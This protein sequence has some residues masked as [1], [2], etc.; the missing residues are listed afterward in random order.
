MKKILFALGLLIVSILGYSQNTHV[1]PSLLPSHALIGGKNG[2]ATDTPFVSDMNTMQMVDRW[3]YGTGFAASDTINHYGYQNV[4]VMPNAINNGT[5]N[6]TGYGQQGWLSNSTTGGWIKVVSPHGV[7]IGNSIVAG[8]TNPPIRTSGLEQNNMN[9]QDS[10]SQIGYYITR[11]CMYPCENMGIGGQTTVQIKARFRRDVLG[12]SDVVGDGRTLP[13][14]LQKAAFCI[15]EGG[16]ND[17]FQ[18]IPIPLATVQANLLWM[19]EQCQEY[20]IPCIVLNSVG[21]GASAPSYS[22]A[23][24]D[25]INTWEASGDLQKY[26]AVVVDINSFWNS[27][28]DGGL[29]AYHNNNF[30]PSSFVNTGDF[31]HFTPVGYDSVAQIIIRHAKLPVL[32]KIAFQSVLD[33]TNP[34]ANY[35]RPTG[36]TI[37]GSAFFGTASQAFSTSYTLANSAYDT[38]LVTSAILTDTA[39]ITITSSS[40]SGSVSGWSNIL[41]HLTNNPTGQVWYTQRPPMSGANTGNVVGTTLNLTSQTTATVP[42]LTINQSAGAT[43]GYGVLVNMSAGSTQM[44]INGFANTTPINSSILNVF[45]G[46]GTSGQL[47]SQST[48]GSQFNNWVIGG[49]AAAAATGFGLGTYSGGVHLNPSSS[50]TLAGPIVTI[51]AASPTGYQYI[52]S[53]S[54]VNYPALLLNQYYSSLTG[55][56]DTVP[57]L[58]LYATYNDTITA[59]NGGMLGGVHLRYTLTNIGVMKLGGFWN[60]YG[61]NWLNGLGGAT[62]IGTT[63]VH[64]SAKLD[65][66]DSVRGLLPPRMTS[67]QISHIGYVK[68]ATVTNGGSGYTVVPK[69][70][71]SGGNGSGARGYITTSSSAVSAFTIV[72][73]GINY[74]GSSPVLTI[75][76]GPGVN[77]AVTLNVSGPDTGLIVYNATTNAI[78]YFN[79]TVWVPLA[80]L[81]HT[82]TTPAAGGTV[83]LVNNQYNIVNSS[84]SLLALT[85]N[86]P[87]SPNNGDLVYIKYT[88]AVT[89]V[90]YGGGTVVDGITFPIAGG[91]VM[92][93]YDSSTTSWY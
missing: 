36:I 59:T 88:Q 80:A 27:G 9:I 25:S 48:I 20:Q 12:I 60:D 1:Y 7:I 54:N 77:A 23:E 79:G 64:G 89:T 78:Q 47:F 34:P 19:V 28:V 52:T 67:T 68:S 55:L 14:A 4:S 85:V 76:N 50:V 51:D 90:T 30:H 33:P 53:T 61:Y 92:L 69:G 62:G 29:N 11:Y 42:I 93:T 2:I 16:V 66:T 75:S 41:Y 15:I 8:H 17:A 46:I 56:N 70:I 84:G 32:D 22:L 43:Q 18:T 39:K 74:G 81:A 37:S 65:I 83:N 38:I 5:G 35:N 82:I 71:V 24:V 49:N 86:L 40:G 87:S 31:I 73:P 13:T 45:G 91:L 63:N 6:W 57:C 58:N 26:G 44:F 3:Y 21:Q 10:L 72:D